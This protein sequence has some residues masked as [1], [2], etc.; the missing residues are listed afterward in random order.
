MKGIDERH[1]CR[2][3][4]DFISFFFVLLIFLVGHGNLFICFSLF[5]NYSFRELVHDLIHVQWRPFLLHYYILKSY[6]LQN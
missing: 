4:K 1:L 6:F 2:S 5:M 3:A